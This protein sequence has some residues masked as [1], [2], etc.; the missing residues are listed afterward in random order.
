[1]HL[2]G[3][4]HPRQRSLRGRA[5]AELAELPISEIGWGDMACCNVHFLACMV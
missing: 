3:T 5:D 4:S 1:M 2:D